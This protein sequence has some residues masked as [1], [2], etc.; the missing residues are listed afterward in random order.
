[1]PVGNKM[2]DAVFPLDVCNASNCWSKRCS[3]N[4]EVHCTNSVNQ[5]L[6]L[7]RQFKTKVLLSCVAQ[8]P[9]RSTCAAKFWLV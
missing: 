2:K 8:L 5:V 9:R 1:M 6:F 7:H 3:S 4:C